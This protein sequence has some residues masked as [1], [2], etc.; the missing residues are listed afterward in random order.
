MSDK[1]ETAK[2]ILF[3]PFLKE[4]CRED[5]ALYLKDIEF[6]TPDGR[7]LSDVKP[8]YTGCAFAVMATR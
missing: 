2:P 3:C 4:P 5:C 6:V 7:K 1:E 8:I